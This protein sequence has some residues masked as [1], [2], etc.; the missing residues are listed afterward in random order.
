MN[1]AIVCRTSASALRLALYT[2][3]AP[4][5]ETT[6][7]ARIIAYRRLSPSSASNCCWN[8]SDSPPTITGAEAAPQTASAS[9]NAANDWLRMRG[10]EQ[11]ATTGIRPADPN[12]AKKPP[13]TSR[14]SAIGAYGIAK[15]AVH[16]A[17]RTATATAPTRVRCEKPRFMRRSAN[18]PPNHVPMKP[19]SANAANA[20]LAC[21]V[22]KSYLRSN[23]AG[24]Q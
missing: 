13:P 5:D 17:A 10:G 3:H 8:S 9:P 24:N 21:G 4:S 12:A 7:V 2:S 22:E 14:T 16:D 23:N 15:P 11:A 1:A 20:T 19:P 6:A 18:G